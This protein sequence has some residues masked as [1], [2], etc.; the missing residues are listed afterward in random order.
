[1]SAKK[2]GCPVTGAG[3][4]GWAWRSA[5]SVAVVAGL[6]MA[7]GSARADDAQT[8]QQM[9]EQIQDLQIKINALVEAQKKMQEMQDKGT[10]PKGS[11]PVYNGSDKVKLT[12]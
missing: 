8:I 6:S 1:M 7:G 9:Q 5:V 2:S 11:A 3:A 10:P 12:V 4:T